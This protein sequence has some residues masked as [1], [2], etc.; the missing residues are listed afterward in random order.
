MPDCRRIVVAEVL[1]TG[2]MVNRPLAYTSGQDIADI[3]ILVINNLTFAADGVIGRKPN[4]IPSGLPKSDREFIW[5]HQVIA[6]KCSF[7]SDVKKR[8]L[9]H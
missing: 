5:N 6:N 4:L 9:L 3:R 7:T 8:L 1:S 2:F